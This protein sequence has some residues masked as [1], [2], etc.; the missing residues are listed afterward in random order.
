MQYL[1]PICQKSFKLGIIP[2]SIGLI[3]CLFAEEKA[4]GNQCQR[5]AVWGN[6]RQHCIFHLGKPKRKYGSSLTAY[7]RQQANCLF[8]HYVAYAWLH[9]PGVGLC[10]LPES[11][12]Y[13]LSTPAGKHSDFPRSKRCEKG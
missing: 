7:K 2:I 13:S 9:R 1:K 5:Y 6:K 8:S 4:S 11:P 10:R 3:C 12:Q